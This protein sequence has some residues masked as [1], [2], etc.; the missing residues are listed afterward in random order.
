MFFRFLWGPW[1]H[2]IPG[3]ANHCTKRIIT[4]LVITVK[5]ILI[6]SLPHVVE[7]YLP[8][9]S[10]AAAHL[11][12]DVVEG[13]AAPSSSISIVVTPRRFVRRRLHGDYSRHFADGFVVWTIG[14]STEQRV[15]DRRHFSFSPR[16][17]ETRWPWMWNFCTIS[18]FYI[19]APPPEIAHVPCTQTRFGYI[20]LHNQTTADTT[21]NVQYTLV[22]AKLKQ[23]W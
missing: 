5:K 1:W 7:D 16:N 18:W 8:P 12:R 20:R 21:Y 2:S 4:S 22:V 14:W 6:S 11:V 3:E 17:D 19:P 10:E 9:S 23:N 15:F 13:D